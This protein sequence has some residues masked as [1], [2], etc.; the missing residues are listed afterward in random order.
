MAMAET[1]EIS[2]ET[3][4]SEI[5]GSKSESELSELTDDPPTS[6]NTSNDNDSISTTSNSVTLL[7]THLKQAPPAIVN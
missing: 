5:E 2:A 3:E 1:R 4:V 7:L 6:S